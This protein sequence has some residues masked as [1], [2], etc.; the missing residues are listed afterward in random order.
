MKQSYIKTVES[1]G[2]CSV[3]R[4]NSSDASLRV[5]GSDSSSII[6]REKY[7]DLGRTTRLIEVAMGQ[8]RIRGRHRKGQTREH[9][10]TAFSSLSR[11]SK[12]GQDDHRDR[13]SI[14]VR[15]EARRGHVGERFLVTSFVKLLLA[16]CQLHRP[17]SNLNRMERGLCR[18]RHETRGAFGLGMGQEVP[19]VGQCETE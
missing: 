2:K 5:I 10:E 6:M 17:D 4:K 19:K 15:A 13:W 18:S 11:G 9:T 16:D 12:Y 7:E 3:R 1:H 14:G 8:S